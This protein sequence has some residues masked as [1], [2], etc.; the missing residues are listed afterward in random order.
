MIHM[1]CGSTGAGKTTYSQSLARK[2]GGVVFS[3]D[4]WMVLLFGNDAPKNLTPAW[5]QPR[6]E[7]CETQI[8]SSVLQLGK[9]GIPSILDLGFQQ[10]KHRRKYIDFAESSELS[11]KLH[12]LDVDAK[13]RW[14]REQNRN[15][16]HGETYH[17]NISRPMFDYIETTWEPP[18]LSELLA[19]NG[20]RVM[21]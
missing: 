6:V 17:L 11:V 10:F 16:D 5:L 9:L 20:V 2:I 1:T 21:G 13:V 19:S 14:S 18:A 4:E 3:I 15:R 7:R 12:F 8:R